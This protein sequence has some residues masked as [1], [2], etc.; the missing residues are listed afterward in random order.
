M[1]RRVHNYA[2]LVAIV[3]LLAVV[4]IGLIPRDAPIETDAERAHRIA[5]EL[6]CPFCSGESIAEAPSGIGSD[7]RALI[8][9]QIASGLSDEEIFDYYVSVYTERVLLSPPLSGWGLLLWAL[10][11]LLLAAGT[12]A[13]LRRRRR[14]VADPAGAVFASTAALEDARGAVARDLAD[15]DVEEAVGELDAAA[16]ARLRAVYQA[17]RDALTEAAIRPFVASPGDRGRMVAGAAVLIGGALVVTV[18]VVLTIRHRSPGD[19]VTG[20]IASAA[21]ELDFSTI[22]DEE[23]EAT[24]AALPDSVPIRLALAARY[25]NAGE[26]SP[27]LEHY[28]E[29]LKRERRPEALANVGWMTF[30]SGDPDTALEFVEESLAVTQDLPLPHWYLANI[31][32]HGFADAAGAVAPLET[33]LAFQLSEEF[34]SMVTDL[35]AEVRA[36]S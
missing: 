18:F 34:R 22:S 35:L 26:F 16:G 17:E 20:G 4:V 15:L 7:L 12:L 13:V 32:Y 3:A 28:I 23:L 29:I 21:Q 1:S 10:P 27:A 9:D 24:V 25:F 5:G 8:D 11:L 33:L 31:R 2:Y 6:R 14:A 36:A 30:Q 19:F